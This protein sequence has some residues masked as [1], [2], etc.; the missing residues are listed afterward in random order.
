MHYYKITTYCLERF[1]DWFL[2]KAVGYRAYKLDS[3]LDY[4]G[5]LSWAAIHRIQ[6]SVYMLEVEPDANHL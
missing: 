4:W 3:D 6:E 2:D 1:L 5:T